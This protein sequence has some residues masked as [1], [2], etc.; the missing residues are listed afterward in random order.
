MMADIDGPSPKCKY[1]CVRLY[2]RQKYKIRGEK[3]NCTDR[4]S[5]IFTTHIRFTKKHVL[6]LKK[7]FCRC[8][9]VQVGTPAHLHPG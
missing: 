4:L 3:M 5:M 9:R 6:Y 2:A 1:K 8:Q 7:H